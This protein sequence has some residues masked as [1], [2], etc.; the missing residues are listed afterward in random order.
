MSITGS[1]RQGGVSV[2]VAPGGALR[3]LELTAEALRGGG[4]ALAGAILRT[5]REA[6]AEANERARHAVAAELGPLGDDEL[7]G[8]GLG[9]EEH[10]AERS[11]D[12]TPESWRA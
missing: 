12:T 1:A 5:V 3:S 4:P 2:E 11:E 10:L 6:A 9:R 8:L 7:T